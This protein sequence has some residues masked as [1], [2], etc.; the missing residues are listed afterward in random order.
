MRRQRFVA[1]L[2]GPSGFAFLTVAAAS[3]VLA[4][5]LVTGHRLTK[6]AV[7]L[8]VAG[9]CWVL[10][11]Y[12]IPLLMMTTGHG[13]PLRQANGTWFIWVVGTESVA[14][15]AASL[16]PHGAAGTL[17]D[18]ASVCWAIGLLQYLLTA[19][20]ALARLLLEPVAPGE[21]IPPYRV[22]SS[23]VRA[24]SVSW[25]GRRSL[26]RRRTACCCRVP[27]SSACA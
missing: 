25:P 24:P 21:L 18:L 9:A 19:T 23:C 13:V 6:A 20:L 3:D 2:T 17:S 11:G 22:G 12:G 16:A 10:L 15:A 4:S 5:R 7:L 1:D 8:A 26:S 27:S 14:V